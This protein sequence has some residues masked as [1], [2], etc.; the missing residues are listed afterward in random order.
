MTHFQVSRL[1][2]SRMRDHVATRPFRVALSA[3]PRPRGMTAG[4]PVP[5]A[6]AGLYRGESDVVRMVP[7]ETARPESTGLRSMDGSM[8]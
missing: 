8:P 6:T 3:V 1:F 7:L 2:N 5:G 4:N